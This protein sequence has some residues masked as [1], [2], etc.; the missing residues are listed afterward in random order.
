MTDMIVVYITCKDVSQATS[1]GKHLLKKRFCACVNII[2]A[3][4]SIYFWPPLSDSFEENDEAILLVKT[5]QSKF[6][7]LENEVL[8]LHSYHLPC[9]MAFPIQ[10]INQ[11]YYEWIKGEVEKK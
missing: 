4:H 1:I 8:T 7:M 2:P 6:Q 10:Q 3:M 5:M 11:K 9:I